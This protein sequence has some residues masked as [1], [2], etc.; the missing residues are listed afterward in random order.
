MEE[1]EELASI[2][3]NVAGLWWGRKE[4]KRRKIATDVSLG[5]I[6]P[7]RKKKKG[8]TSNVSDMMY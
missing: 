3:I 1:Q 7:C 6:F 5:Q 8:L 4:E 2:S